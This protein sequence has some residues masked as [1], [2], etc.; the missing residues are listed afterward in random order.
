M[1]ATSG[2]N[3]NRPRVVT[4]EAVADGH[5]DKLCDQISDAVL[6]ACLEQDP[7]SR[8]AVETAF[9][10]HTV[11]LLGEVTTRARLDYAAIV[12][13]VLAEVGHGG[14][15]WGLDPGKVRVLVEISE[16]EP[17]I[18]DAVSHADG[19]VGAGDQ[20]LMFGYA[21]A[22]GAGLMP[23]S[24]ALARALMLRQRAVRRMPEGAILGPDAKSQVSVAFANGTPVAIE[25][26]VLSSQHVDGVTPAQVR[27]VLREQV[28][29]VVLPPE[30][31]KPG[32]RFYVNPSGS[33]VQGG[34]I[35]DAGV[36]GRK[37]IADSYGGVAHHGGGAFSGKDATKVDRSAAYAAR[38]VARTVVAA[39]VARRCEVHVAY[40]IGV[41]EPVAIDVETFGTGVE[42]DEALAARVHAAVATSLKPREIIRRLDLRRPIYRATAAF[43]HFGRSDVALPWE[44]PHAELAAALAG[45][46]RGA[47]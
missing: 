6:D 34:P 28:I 10:G 15:R 11:M 3:H 12:R 9:K 43:G 21:D 36:T 42:P 5:P 13:G 31:V 19:D 44:A 40:A 23:L 16:Q 17:E 24:Y 38:Q 33:F 47:S 46:A 4:S 37:I 32:T 14:G 8:V 41:P 20:G 1:T 18:G 35:A 45:L 7:S 27:C 30:L 25:A 26:V 2:T 29:D 22:G 39:G